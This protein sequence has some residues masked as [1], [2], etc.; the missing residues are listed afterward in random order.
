MNK[1][2]KDSYREASSLAAERAHLDRGKILWAADPHTAHYYGIKVMKGLSSAEIG[3]DAGLDWPVRNQ[4]VDAQNW[5]SD[6]ATAYLDA[7]TTPTIL[8]L[9]KADLFDAKG[10]WRAL[11]QHRRP[12]E[13]ANLTAMTVYEWQPVTAVEGVGVRP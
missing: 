5:S 4:A 7:S 1:Y 13:L 3:N 8:V 10:A 2:D 12:T 11:I 6:Q 9:S